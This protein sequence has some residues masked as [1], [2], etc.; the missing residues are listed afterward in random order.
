MKFTLTFK[1]PDVLDQID[2]QF[3]GDD[4]DTDRDAARSLAGKFLEYDEYIYIEFDT[5]TGEARVKPV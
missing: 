1:H 2:E 4:R 3:E 5:E